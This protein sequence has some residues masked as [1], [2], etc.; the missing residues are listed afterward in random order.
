VRV[1]GVRLRVIEGQVVPAV[2]VVDPERFQA[3]CVE[4][5]VASWTARGFSTTTIDTMSEY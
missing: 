3:A 5:F 2:G 1:G 4:A